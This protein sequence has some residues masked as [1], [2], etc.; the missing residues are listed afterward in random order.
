MKVEEEQ[1]QLKKQNKKT[2][3]PSKKQ[4]QKDAKKYRLEN[5]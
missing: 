5:T 2:K 1:F 3:T 4:G